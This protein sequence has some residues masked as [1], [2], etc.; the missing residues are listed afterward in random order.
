MMPCLLPPPVQAYHKELVDLVAERVGAARSRGAR[1]G[2]EDASLDVLGPVRCR[3]PAPP[4]EIVER[5][6]P[7]FAEI[8]EF[9]E[10]RERRFTAWLDNVTILKK[11][12]ETDGMDLWAVHRSFNLEA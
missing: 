8:W 2:P 4:H 11:M 5:C 10:T 9:V 1:V 7:R 3:A 12:S 6:R